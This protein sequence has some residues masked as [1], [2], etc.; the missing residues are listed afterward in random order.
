VVTRDALVVCIGNPA[1]GDDGAGARVAEL[2]EG[3]VP[4]GVG[5]LAVH[6]LDVA[7][8]VDISTAGLVV[9]VDAERRDG[10]VE[11]YPI[12]A[13][14]EA[15]THTLS[16]GALLGLAAALYG[17]HPVAYLVSVPAAAMPHAHALSPRTEAACEDAAS[18]VLDLLAPRL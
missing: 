2:L 3:R 18:V 14:G 9:L 16:P 17:A 12:A 4:A 7:L 11:A 6:Q 13:S 1:R 5:V 15:T 8:A 10:R